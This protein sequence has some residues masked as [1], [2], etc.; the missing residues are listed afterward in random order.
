MPTA[1]KSLTPPA[2]GIVPL[3]LAAPSWRH[4]SCLLAGH[5]LPWRG[6]SWL[7][8]VIFILNA[9]GFSE[10]RLPPP[11][12]QAAEPNQHRSL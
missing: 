10:F 3:F 11:A 7:G 8:C 9:P 6:F 5:P 12:R 1:L 2:P 4:H